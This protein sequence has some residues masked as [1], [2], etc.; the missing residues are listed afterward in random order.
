MLLPVLEK[1]FVIKQYITFSLKY[2]WF[3]YVGVNLNIMALKWWN[4]PGG[5]D[6][7]KSWRVTICSSA[8]MLVVWIGNNKKKNQ[9]LSSEVTFRE[10]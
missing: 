10:V 1:S 3:N 4:A 5:D 6:N 8:I 2:S 9:N 7:I